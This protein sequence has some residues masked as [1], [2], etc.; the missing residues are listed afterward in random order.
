MR[1]FLLT[2]FLLG[3]L[4]FILWRPAIG[5]FLWIWVSVMN[6]HRMTFGFAYDFGFAQLIAIAVLLGLLFSRDQKRLPVTPVTVT[7]FLLVMWMCI[8]TFFALDTDAALPMW[9]KVM[10]IQ[11]MVF[12]TLYLLHSRQHI[13]ILIAVVAGSVAFFGIK[14]GVFTVLGGGENRVWGPAD[15]FIE[16][17]NSLALATIMTI[18]MLYYLFMQVKKRWMRWGLLAAMLLCGFSA[19]GSYSRGALLAIGAMVAVLWWKSRTKFATGFLLLLLV[20]V[21]IGFMPEKWEERMWSIQNYEEDSSSLG[22]INAWQMAMNLAKDRPL[23]GG[24][25]DIYNEK[26]FGRYAPNPDDVH[27]AHSIYFQMLGEHG[28]VGL[29]LFLLLW[30]LVWRDTSTI[31]RRSRG[32]EDLRWATELA[33]MIQVSLVGYAVGGAFLNLAYFDVPYYLLVAVVLT[34]LQVEKRLYELEVKQG[35]PAPEAVEEMVNE[36]GVVAVRQLDTQARR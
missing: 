28:Y 34:R 29:L 16:E 11:L 27:S 7:L 8:T 24:G 32:H 9:E 4:P 21:A 10:K 15:S 12:V 19:L 30:V 18:P 25:F 6:P 22:R 5:V 2:A 20:P 31:I 26:V 14:G 35:A 3:S 36:H 17:N 1:D 23:N 13:Q 33:R